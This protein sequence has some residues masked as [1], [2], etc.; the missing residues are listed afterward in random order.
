M[1]FPTTP[2]D[3]DVDLALGADITAAP[4]TWTWTTVP[5]TG[6]GCVQQKGGGIGVQRG[7][8]DGGIQAPPSTCT[9]VVDNSDGRWSPDN[10]TGVWYGLL[11]ENTPVRIRTNEGTT[12]VRWTGFLTSLPPRWAEGELDRYVPVT[13]SGILQ[14]LQRGKTPLRSPL[15]RSISGTSTPPVAYWPG[16]DDGQATTLAEFFGGAPMRWTGALTPASAGPDGSN[17]LPEFTQ[18][19]GISGD[20]PTHP[21]TG[22][23]SVACVFNFPAAPTGDTSI[24]RWN[25]TGSLPMWQ[26]M[27]N[28]IGG[29]DTLTLEA[30]DATGTLVLSDPT[31][32]GG[33]T[34]AYGSWVMLQ[35]SAVQ[36][37]TGIDYAIAYAADLGNGTAGGN[38]SS[39]TVA[40]QTTGVI[41]RMGLPST[42][43]TNGIH[44]GH[45]AAWDIDIGPLFNTEITALALSGYAG[46]SVDARAEQLASEEGLIGAVFSGSHIEMGPQ[47]QDTFLNLMRECEAASNGRLIEVM[48]PAGTSSLQLALLL[49]TDL[50]NQAVALTLNHN[51]G[52]LVAPFEPVNDDQARRND[53]TATR[54]GA[55]GPGSSARVV[56]DTGKLTPAKVGTYDD[57]VSVNVWN[58]DQLP[59]QASWRVKVGTVEGLRFP[60]VTF[61]LFAS[62]ALI[63]QWLTCDIGSR[64]QITNPPTGMAPDTVDLLIEGWVEVFDALTWKVQLFCSP[65]EPWRVFQLAQTSGDTDP[66]LGR[67]A[68]DEAC[69]LRAAAT[70]TALSFLVDPNRTRWTTVADDFPLDIR[71][72]GEVARVS[73]IATTAGTFVAI[74]AGN[75]TD[76]G[77][78]TAVLPA[79]AAADL[80]LVVGAIRSSGTGT[81]NAPAGY[82][83][84]PI[85]RDTDNVGVFAKVAAA[86]E[87][88]PTV[89]FNNGVAGDTCSVVALV[90]RGTPTSLVDLADVVVDNVAQ[91]NGSAQDVAYGGLY[92]WKQEGTI[93]LLV[94]WKQDDYTSVA[95]PAGFTEAGEFS[96]TVGNDQSLYIA[97]KIDT[98]PSLTPE[99]TV[100]VTGGAAAISRSA[101]TAL[102]AGYQTFTLSTRNVNAIPGGK[103][104]TAGTKVEVEDAAVQAL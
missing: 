68:E 72:G 46:F 24:L 96:S 31:T 77:P 53:V 104:Q 63:T 47:P 74:G 29:I 73:S 32:F 75:H 69:A 54:T 4:T 1:A 58:D 27:V 78:R 94:V 11:G 93:Q 103:A 44:I 14:R 84:L 5:R 42:A 34:E 37:G 36:N 98:T 100:V 97:Y 86:S 33:T 20:V 28:P 18:F 7:A 45:F 30:Y 25:T 59:D 50:E 76:N 80:I 85:F 22:R 67:L 35:V 101:V 52:H 15:V 64:V 3:F 91:L 95:P 38:V 90:L 43:K 41:T 49:N 82:T 62:P 99:G 60:V 9:F 81:V 61:D 17:P 21:A 89:T 71:V 12:S 102:A 23:W 83:R 70:S 87:S 39:G 16:E 92:P 6:P 48:D 88:N 56:A 57:S 13:A 26:V 2:L 19:V 51:M 55:S 65:Y 40:T 79:F 8:R 66:F 10:P